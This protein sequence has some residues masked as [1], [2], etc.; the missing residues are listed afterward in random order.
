MSLDYKG[1]FLLKNVSKNSATFESAP[2]ALD[3]LYDLVQFKIFYK[4][5]FIF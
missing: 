3:K 4:T 2:N 1:V 5:S